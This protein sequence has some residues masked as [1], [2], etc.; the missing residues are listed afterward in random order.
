M[1]KETKLFVNCI[2]SLVISHKK[3][4]NMEFH[5]KD[6]IHDFLLNFVNVK[7]IYFDSYCCKTHNF[8]FS[9]SGKIFLQKC[10]HKISGSLII[11]II[12]ILFSCKTNVRKFGPHLSTVIL[13][14]SH[15]IHRDTEIS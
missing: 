8:S 2:I 6:L 7:V 4:E 15:I 12:E 14:A 10:I 11:S 13:W 5:G 9:A 3:L 1:R